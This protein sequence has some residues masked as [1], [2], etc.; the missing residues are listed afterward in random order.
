MV[1][2]AK[3]RGSRSKDKRT[4]SANER[5]LATTTSSAPLA[6]ARFSFAAKRTALV[7]SLHLDDPWL[8]ALLATAF[9]LRLVFWVYTGRTWEDALITAL[10]SENFYHGL[11]LTHFR[12]DDPRPLHGFTSPISVLLPLV[13]DRFHVGWGL[14]FEKLV[15]SRCGPR[16][17]VV[18]L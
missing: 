2:R 7:R 13:A 6:S 5:G 17:G 3:G 18:R 16:D 12:I 15:S 10:H 1:K 11:G 14:P 4:I 9:L 8:V